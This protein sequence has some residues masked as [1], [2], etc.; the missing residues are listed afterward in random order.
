MK[1]VKGS[2]GQ[3]KVEPRYSET[4]M[5]HNVK[6]TWPLGTAASEIRKGHILMVYVHDI[7]VWCGKTV[8]KEGNNVP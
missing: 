6:I 8:G 4:D 1:C 3:H 5:K 7:C 2:G